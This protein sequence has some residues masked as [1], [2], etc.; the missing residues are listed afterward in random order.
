M[1]INDLKEAEECV[2]YLKVKS[3]QVFQNGYHNAHAF[4]SYSQRP[5][6][7]TDKNDFKTTI[8]VQQIRFPHTI[9]VTIG[10]LIN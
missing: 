9:I 8:P 1:K 7:P 6:D 5:D 10:M 3:K 4:T 2:Q